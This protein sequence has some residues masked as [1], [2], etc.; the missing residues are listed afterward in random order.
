M[1][2]FVHILTQYSYIYILLYTDVT[3]FITNY[4]IGCILIHSFICASHIL[5]SCMVTQSCDLRYSFYINNGISAQSEQ[6]YKVLHR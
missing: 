6:K 3:D 2:S 1:L 5:M 4:Y